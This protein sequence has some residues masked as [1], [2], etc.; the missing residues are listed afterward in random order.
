MILHSEAFWD[1]R[2]AFIG[3]FTCGALVGDITMTRHTAT[4]LPCLKD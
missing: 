1:T 2:E 3:T 4:Y